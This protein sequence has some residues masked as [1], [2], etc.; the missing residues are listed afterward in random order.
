[1]DHAEIKQ[2][3]LD[4]F[5]SLFIHTSESKHLYDWKTHKQCFEQYFMCLC[6]FLVCYWKL[7]QCERR[8]L[9]AAARRQWAEFAGDAPTSWDESLALFVFLFG[10][11]SVLLTKLLRFV[12]MTDINEMLLGINPS[13][14]FQGNKGHGFSRY[15]DTCPCYTCC[16]VLSRTMVCSEIFGYLVCNILILRSHSTFLN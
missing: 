5:H 9:P 10:K 8:E 1:M 6:P 11:A 7:S 4:S 2:W 12:S 3:R 15:L 14:I 16:V 13:L